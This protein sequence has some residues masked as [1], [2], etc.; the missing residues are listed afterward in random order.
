MKKLSKSTILKRIKSGKLCCPVC[1]GYE[2]N[3]RMSENIV[4][5]EVTC[6]KCGQLVSEHGFGTSDSDIWDDIKKSIKHPTYNKIFKW[7]EKDVWTWNK[8]F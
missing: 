2:F 4:M 1:G 6:K 5:W 3:V 7:I 8:Q